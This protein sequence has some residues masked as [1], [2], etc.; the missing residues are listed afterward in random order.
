MLSD[1]AKSHKAKLN[2]GD[3]TV[4][5]LVP[6]LLDKKNYIADIRN[7]KFY[8]EHGLKVTKVHQVLTF[9]QERWLKP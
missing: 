2:I 9:H 1:Y 4:E 8:M 7:I 6:N 5:K 3:D